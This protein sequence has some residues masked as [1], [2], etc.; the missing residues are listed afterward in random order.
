MKGKIDKETSM[1]FSTE[2]PTYQ[3]PLGDEHESRPHFLLHGMQK[4][5]RYIGDFLALLFVAAFTG[6][7]TGTSCAGISRPD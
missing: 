1:L 3:D 6:F 2:Y 5:V 7:C 4:L